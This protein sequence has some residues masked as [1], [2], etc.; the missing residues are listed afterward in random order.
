M[1]SDI[2][3]PYH[4]DPTCLI[5]QLIELR[6]IE[7]VVRNSSQRNTHQQNRKYLKTYADSLNK[8]RLSVNRK[9]FSLAIKII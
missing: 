7:F 2:L 5:V 6:K 8:G 3:R 9:I 1:L 4:D